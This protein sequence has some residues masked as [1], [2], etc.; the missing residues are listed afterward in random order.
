FDIFENA[1]CSRAREA[2][3]RRNLGAS[4]ASRVLPQ[5]YA[6][7]LHHYRF[8]VESVRGANETDFP[9][10]ILADPLDLQIAKEESID[11][12]EICSRAENV[13]WHHHVQPVAGALP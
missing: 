13:G 2:T 9:I 6:G 8:D 4:G 3:P 5:Q 12:I 11:Y 7:Q 1:F 10:Q